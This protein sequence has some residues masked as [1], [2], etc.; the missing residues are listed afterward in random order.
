MTVSTDP[1]G[2]GIVGAGFIADSH[3]QAA[4]GHPGLRLAAV[5][6]RN[7]V[8]AAALAAKYGATVS[9]GLDELLADPA[10]DIV[11]IGTPND[12]H[13]ELALAT[14][15]AGKH[16]LLEKP[17]ALS[18]A[19]SQ[20]VADAFTERGLTLLIGHTHRHSDYAMSVSAALQSGAVG[21]PRSMRLAIAGGWIWG[22]W[23]AWVL[24][25][26]RSGGHAFHN[27]VHLYDLAHWWMGSP[28]ERVFTMGQKI[29]AAALE[30]DDALVA[31]LEF[32][33]GSTAVCEISRGE[34]PRSTNV[35]EIVVHGT[36]GTLTRRWNSDGT[37][38]FTDEVV[39]ALGAAGTSPFGRQLGVM[40]DAIVN[41]TPVFPAVA[42]AIHSIAIAVAVE[43]SARTGEVVDVSRQEGTKA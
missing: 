28:V 34:R 23:G 3:A 16:L 32:A 13:A 33:N 4:Q 9:P 22:S 11:I 7:P 42:D 1:L 12:T 25:P 36:T 14:A 37:V 43:Q 35:F 17:L 41:G 18:V 2:I 39:G 27:G 30:I 10:V 40:H 38:A 5:N 8:A 24:D 6:D 31:T 19:D 26:K 29:T 21:T 15:A 20:R